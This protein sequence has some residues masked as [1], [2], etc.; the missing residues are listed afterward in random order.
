[1]D[2]LRS[3][4]RL[5]RNNLILADAVGHLAVFEI[6]HRTHGLLE[7]G[8]GTLVNTNH[9]FSSELQGCFVDTSAP[10]SKGNS[11]HRYDKVTA[12]LS[13]AFGRIDVPFAQ[14]LMATHAG[15]LTSL[16]RHPIEGSGS[17][18]ISASI[19]LPAQRSMLFCHGLPCR[20]RY[21]SFTIG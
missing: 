8:D 2:Y 17:T 4:P 7:T 16:C 19:F 20:G 9:F 18:T 11:F 5:G 14:R 12:E 1:V 10:Q 13:A 6:G 3:V 15:P 21:D